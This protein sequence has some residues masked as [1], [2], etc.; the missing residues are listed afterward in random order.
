MN[1]YFFTRIHKRRRES[2]GRSAKGKKGATK[3]TPQDTK[4]KGSFGEDEVMLK[5]VKHS[6][7]Q[8][9]FLMCEKYALPVSRANVGF[10][11]LS[12]WIRVQSVSVCPM[13]FGVAQIN[14]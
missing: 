2:I 6:N 5:M 14:M 9:S 12:S 13:K 10:S 7:A 3:E 1:F 8:L 11:K 4:G